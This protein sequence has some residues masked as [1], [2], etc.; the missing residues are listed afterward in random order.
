MPC[1]YFSGE[2][3]NSITYDDPANK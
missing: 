2:D 3:S 1:M